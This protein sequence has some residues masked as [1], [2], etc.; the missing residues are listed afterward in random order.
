MV[1]PPP[2]YAAARTPLATPALG[3]GMGAAVGLGLLAG[4][5]LGLSVLAAL[6]APLLLLGCLAARVRVLAWSLLL[7]L[8]LGRQ[9]A[10]AQMAPPLLAGVERPA[11][12]YLHG[13]V[14]DVSLPS[15]GAQRFTLALEA[16]GE[17]RVA[18]ARPHPVVVTVRQRG[19]TRWRWHDLVP[20]SRVSLLARLSE[21][22]DGLRAVVTDRRG[23]TVEATGRGLGAE[24]T[25]ARRKASWVFAQRLG[26]HDGGLARAL[27]LGDR[28]RLAPGDRDLFR[29]TGQAHLLAV[30]GLHVG[31]LLGG[32]LLVLRALGLPLAFT[33][34]AGLTTAALYVP[35][36]GSPPSAVRA[37]LA[38]AAWFIAALL[39]RR[40]ESLA[41]LALIALV[42]LVRW[43]SSLQSVSFQLS[44]AAVTSILVLSTRIRSLLVR[45]RPVIVGLLPPKRAPVRTS[46][47]VSLAAWLGTAPFIATY[48]GRLCPA[49]AFIA[50]PAIPITAVILG[51]GFVLLLGRD[52]PWLAG[53]AAAC[54]ELATTVLRLWLTLVQELGLAARE[55][56]A[57]TLLWWLLYATG[58]GAAASASRP[59]LLRPGLALMVG[60]LLLLLLPL[61]AP[62]LS[63]Q[64][65]P[66]KIAPPAYDALETRMPS[67]PT[68]TPLEG[69]PAFA[70]LVLGLLAFGTVAVRL[71][72]LQRGAAAAAGILGLAATAALGWAGLLA[73]LAPFLI[74]TLLGKLPGAERA[75]AR[76][77]KQVLSNGLPAL[78]G[79]IAVLAGHPELGCPFFL[80][81]LACLGADTCATEIGTRY[82]GTPFRWL[83]RSPV[84]SG[85]SGGVT[86]AGLLASVLGGLLAP[87]AF[88]LVADLAWEAVALLGAAGFAGGLL[89]SVL[90]GTLQYRATDPA[91]GLA[92]EQPPRAG[93]RHEH[94]RGFTWLDNDAVN[95]V[96][97][98]AAAAIAVCLAALL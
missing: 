45:P 56:R 84:A 96:S 30:S 20:G 34:I 3:V 16:L 73:L 53:A 65:E 24:L 17:P 15:R 64:R 31:L 40:P 9:A 25:L 44:F 46:L 23:V 7:G 80:G 33:W 74:A 14:R 6:A 83:G 68:P 79:A 49:A 32:L 63:R 51:S 19:R 69:L 1:C 57:P 13:T 76:S 43:P 86:L 2:P 42:V 37:G 95:L 60:L 10:L 61:E 90:G 59:R 81:A 21:R 35:F 87:L 66:R 48:I 29:A 82:G 67:F 22:R 88:A 41:I 4:A 71:G 78:S 91:T 77:I 54:F 89:D 39:A 18:L 26:R 72:W 12:H 50:L 70:G 8:V 97:G 47:A 85:E 28:G 98:V 55:A 75:G 52:V 27:I 38:A 92:T 58:F 94:I 93:E 36:A 5:P 62:G 11:I